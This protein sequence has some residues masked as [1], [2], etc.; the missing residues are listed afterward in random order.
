MTSMTKKELVK[1]TKPRYLKADKK[2][3]GK[4]LDEFCSNT[5]FNRKYAITTL[6]AGYE[7]DRVEKYGRQSRKVVYGSELMLPVIKIWELLEYPCGVRL[8]PA[9]A[10]TAK[11][12][13]RYGELIINQ[14][15]AEQLDQISAKTLDRRLGKEREIR[16]L[17]RNRGTTRH[18]S[19]LKSSIPIRITEWDTNELGFMEM[20]TVA[21]NG[22]DPSGE[23][24]YSLDLVEIYSG[25][26]EQIAVMGK[27]QLGVVRAIDQVKQGL[28]FQIK[29]CDS[30]SGSEFINWHLVDYCQKHSLYFTRSRPDRKNDNAYVEQKNNTHIR[31][32]LGYGRYDTK[33][34]LKMINGLYSNEL[35]LF[36]NFFRPVMKIKSKEKINN[37]VCK[38][39][40]DQAQ[41]P[42]QRLMDSNQ[43]S[44]GKKQELEKLYLSLNP[45]E[46][47]RAI[48]EKLNRIKNFKPIYFK[49]LSTSMV[50]NY[51]SQPVGAMV[52]FLND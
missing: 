49:N 16:R 1:A 9:L 45:V 10:L 33:E 17:K 18:G 28:P 12:M 5:G 51:V 25:W 46:L 19:L 39:T 8:Q 29:G 21:H 31:H 42:Y 47:K 23:F 44:V 34:Q 41:T 13:M 36:N 4:I 37:S 6:S 48:D 24:I 3:K 50:R 15:V 32:W 26:S 11:A 20:D 7:Y 14:K 2:S 40:Y 43:I 52:R 22:G 35:R 27:G 30:D 38:K